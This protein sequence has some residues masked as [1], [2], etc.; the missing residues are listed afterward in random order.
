LFFDLTEGDLHVHTHTS[1]D[2][3]NEDLLAGTHSGSDLLAG[4]Q[5]RAEAKEEGRETHIIFPVDEVQGRS[6]F[7]RWAVIVWEAIG[8]R[9]LGN[10]LLEEIL[11]VEEDEDGRLLEQR[12]LQDVFEQGQRLVHTVHSVVFKEHCG[13]DKRGEVKR[14][15]RDG[16]W[17][18]PERPSKKMMALTL[19]K[20]WIHFL[21]SLLWPPTSTTW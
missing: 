18:Y 8:E 17:L 6:H 11:L 16:P 1:G 12:V 5:R 21:R 7:S 20:Q 3:L 2:H 14:A 13:G 4:L 19:S 15:R 9:V 10:H